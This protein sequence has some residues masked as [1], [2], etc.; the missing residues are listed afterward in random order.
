MKKLQSYELQEV[1]GAGGM[2]TV[3]KAWHTIQKK[4]FAF[5]TYLKKKISVIDDH[6]SVIYS[7][8][9]EPKSGFLASGGEDK[10]IFLRKIKINKLDE[11][12]L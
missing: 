6:K 4:Y 3:Y 9:F 1:I 8:A 11:R 10:Q 7:L 2:G 12:I 5:T